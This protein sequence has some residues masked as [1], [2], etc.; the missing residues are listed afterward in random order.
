MTHQLEEEVAGLSISPRKD[1]FQKG[2]TGPAK[3]YIHGWN[4]NS[5]GA[6]LDMLKSYGPPDEMTEY[7][8]TWHERDP[9]MRIIV[10]REEIPHAWPVLHMDVL[11]QTVPYRV[12]LDRYS[13]LAEFDGSVFAERTAGVL[14]ARC[15][16]ESMNF[17]AINMAHEVARGMNPATARRKYEAAAKGVSSGNRP[18]IAKRLMFA[19]EVRMA[20]D[21]DRTT[22]K[23]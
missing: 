19:P 6:A 7:R 22:I 10:H 4:E 8:L 12:P 20:R 9:W 17:V 5:K 23:V 16:G 21:P 1:D 15:G 18:D 14:S 11:E 3:K 13:A 2:D